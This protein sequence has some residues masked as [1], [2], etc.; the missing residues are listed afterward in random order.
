MRS[1]MPRSYRLGIVALFR[2]PSQTFA[3]LAKELKPTGYAPKAR[4]RRAAMAGARR[5]TAAAKVADALIAQ[6][7]CSKAGPRPL[8]DALAAR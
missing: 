7:A 6:T 2:G 1:R 3:K 5:N 4:H 8:I